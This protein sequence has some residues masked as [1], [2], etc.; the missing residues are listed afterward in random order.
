[1]RWQSN[2]LLVVEHLTMRRQL[3]DWITDFVDPLVTNSP[4]VPGSVHYGFSHGV[5]G[6]W[7]WLLEQLAALPNLD[8]LQTNIAQITDDGI[9]PLAKL[10]SLRNLKFFH[11][12]KSFSKRTTSPGPTFACTQLTAASRVGT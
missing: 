1:M 4:Q 9:Q 11:P 6:L 12:G 7:S 8:T 10:T 2:P 5:N 3:L